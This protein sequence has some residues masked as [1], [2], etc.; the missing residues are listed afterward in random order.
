MEF[1]FEKN[2][3]VD[4]FR[5]VIWYFTFKMEIENAEYK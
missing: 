2:D 3:A 1:D 5:I 4:L